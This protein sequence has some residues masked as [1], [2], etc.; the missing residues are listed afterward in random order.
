MAATTGETLHKGTPVKGQPPTD[1][2]IPKFCPW[3]WKDPKGLGGEVIIIEDR[4]TR[5]IKSWKDI[6]AE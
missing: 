5:S 1:N 6:S 2:G 4:L 3:D